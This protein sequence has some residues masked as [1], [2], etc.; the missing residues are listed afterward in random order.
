[1]TGTEKRGVG[2][3]DRVDRLSEDLN[4]Q[5]GGLDRV[6][7]DLTKRVGRLGVM[8]EDA[9]NSCLARWGMTRADYGVLTALRSVGE[10]Y[11]LRPT[12]LRE[13]ILLSSGGTSNV[14]NRLLKAE[15]VTRAPDSTDGRSSFVR[16]TTTG[17]ELADEIVK[18]WARVQQDLFRAVP[19]EASQA[20]SDALRRVLIGFGDHEPPEPQRRRVSLVQ[21]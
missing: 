21:P 4:A 15:L 5:I 18:E 2:P 14:L 6:E 19:V 10:P 3:R 17:L 12:D 8:L 13:R 11:E 1:M 9:M 7:Y 20:A 16:L